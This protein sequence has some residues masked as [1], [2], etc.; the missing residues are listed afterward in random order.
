MATQIIM[1]K[2]GMAMKEGIVGRWLKDDGAGVA[3]G[4]P[5]AVIVTKKITYELSAPAAG[6]LRRTFQ[7]KATCPV[8]AI[9][10]YVTAPGEPVPHMD[11]GSL[12][13]AELAVTEMP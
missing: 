13:P 12:A 8:G 1:P 7:A 11:G 3:A 4:E 6:V 9:I 2:L 10:G 5:I